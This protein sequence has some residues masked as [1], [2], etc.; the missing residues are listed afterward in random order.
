MSRFGIR[1]L[2]SLSV[3]LS[4]I[5]AFTAPVSGQMAAAY[6]DSVGP[7][8]ADSA[9]EHADFSWTLQTLR[10]RVDFDV[11]GFRTVTVTCVIP[12]RGILNQQWAADS[13]G[14]GQG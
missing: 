5:G 4:L 8:T 7:P 2:R 11:D 13:S 12:I 6:V 14:R 10:G 9:F 3:S 1:H